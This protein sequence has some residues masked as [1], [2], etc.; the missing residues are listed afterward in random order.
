MRCSTVDEDRVKK[1]LERSD[2]PLSTKRVAEQLGVDW[3]TAKDALDTLEERG[4]VAR[5]EISTRLT[6]WSD[7]E[8]QFSMSEKKNTG[9]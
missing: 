5:T 9:I 6:L 1:Q 7:Q 3:H 4:A 2:S 8:I